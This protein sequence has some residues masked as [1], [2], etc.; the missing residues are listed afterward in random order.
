MY[1]LSI[2][3]FSY[4]FY[5]VEIAPTFIANISLIDWTNVLSGST[6]VILFLAAIP[7]AAAYRKQKLP[8]R[9]A[10]PSNGVIV[11][12]LAV[13]GSTTSLISRLVSW[14]VGEVSSMTLANIVC[15]R[16]V[17]AR[18]LRVVKVKLRTSMAMIAS[19]R[20]SRMLHLQRNF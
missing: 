8:R 5:L 4:S 3:H 11:R 14:L 1:F 15:D 17:M 9:P 20:I 18:S 2:L 12:N 13:T 10:L 7:R 16:R 6:S 19:R